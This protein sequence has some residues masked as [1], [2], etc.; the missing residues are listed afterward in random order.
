MWQLI[1]SSAAVMHIILGA[2]RVRGAQLINQYDA[3][4]AT[5]PSVSRLNDTRRGAL[6]SLSQTE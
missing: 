2:Q 6:L 4:L 3:R 1:S 5:T